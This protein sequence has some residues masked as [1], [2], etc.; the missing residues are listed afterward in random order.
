MLQAL[1][2]ILQHSWL[3]SCTIANNQQ[4]KIASIVSINLLERAEI[5]DVLIVAEVSHPYFRIQFLG[6]NGYYYFICI[7]EHLTI[8]SP[9]LKTNKLFKIKMCDPYIIYTIKKFAPYLTKT[10]SRHDKTV[11]NIKFGLISRHVTTEKWYQDF[12]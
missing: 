2:L 8:G 1:G 5:I 11:Q 3:T 7:V 6:S 12:S 4:Y 9:C 10:T